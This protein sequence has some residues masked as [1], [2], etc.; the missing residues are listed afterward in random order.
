M[1]LISGNLESHGVNFVGPCFSSCCVGL[2]S[3]VLT[4]L[5]G[6]LASCDLCGLFTCKG[7]GRSGSSS[8]ESDLNSYTSP[9]AMLDVMLVMTLLAVL[10][11][12]VLALLAVLLTIVLVLVAVLMTLVLALPDVLMTLE[13]ALLDVVITL[14]LMLLVALFF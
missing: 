14:E 11:T 1:T 13:L 9:E 3:G 7:R 10:L 12:L 8:S 6:L 4:S 5:V 2:L